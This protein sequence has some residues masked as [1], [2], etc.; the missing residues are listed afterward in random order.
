MSQLQTIPKI[1]QRPL[2]VIITH[3]II[4]TTQT[5]QST[6]VLQ[7]VK[8]VIHAMAAKNVMCVMARVHFTATAYTVI[9]EIVTHALQ[10]HMTMAVMFPVVWYVRVRGIAGF[11][12]VQRGMTAQYA[13]EQGSVHI[14]IS[15]NCQT[16]AE[17][18]KPPPFRL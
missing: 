4:T 2:P 6:T 8:P 1:H 9:R 13:A 14:A 7:T 12:K 17:R 5:E 10:E 3:T 11:A 15:G 16:K 18:R